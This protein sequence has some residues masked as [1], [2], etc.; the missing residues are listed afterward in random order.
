M[1]RLVNR[2]RGEP[3]SVVVLFL[4]GSHMDGAIRDAV[5]E[6]ICAIADDES[7][8]PESLSAICAIA[9]KSAGFQDVAGVALVGYSAGCQRVRAM[10]VGGA[11]PA[12]V[13]VIDGTHATLPQDPVNNPPPRWQF[14][15]WRDYAAKAR[16]GERLFVATATQMSYVERIRFGEPGR[17]VSTKHVLEDALGVPL[18]SGTELHEA[19]LH[20]FSYPSKDVDK[21]A[22]IHQQRIVLPSM[23]RTY[24]RNWMSGWLEPPTVR[25]SKAPRPVEPEPP[26]RNPALPL[27]ERAVLCSLAEMAAGVCE[28]PDGSNT[29]PR[30]REYLAPAHRDGKYLGLSAAEWCA[31]GACWTALES[32]R[33]YDGRREVMPHP[34]VVSGIEIEEAAKRNGSWRSVASGYVPRVGDLAIYKRGTQAW[35]RHV[36]RVETRPNHAAEFRTIGGNEDNRWRLTQRRMSDS[37]L[38]G[39]VE[40]PV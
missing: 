4:V 23:L 40:Y 15:V 6:D 7:S 5:G 1:L 3:R 17:A 39:F 9:R 16:R 36:C 26:W 2:G 35:Q 11:D 30:I 12:A 20:A 10:L 31:A 33:G 14:D 24:V 21:E 29:S 18:P 13:A 37:D 32:L 22:H 28:I 25:P 38:L 19:G 8:G 27:G 34:Y